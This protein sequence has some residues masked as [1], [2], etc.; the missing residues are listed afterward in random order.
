MHQQQQ[1]Q[2]D[3]KLKGKEK[4]SSWLWYIFSI[5]YM[6]ILCNFQSLIYI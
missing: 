4:V 1:Q 5:K 2:T 6:L 3:Q